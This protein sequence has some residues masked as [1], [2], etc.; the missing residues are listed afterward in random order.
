ML[1]ILF[2]YMEETEA[3]KAY[4]MRTRGK[5]RKVVIYHAL[6][7]DGLNMVGFPTLQST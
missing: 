6:P 5:V 1:C 3:L 4:T 2:L 7:S